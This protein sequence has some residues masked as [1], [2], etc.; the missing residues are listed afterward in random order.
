MRARDSYLKRPCPGWCVVYGLHSINSPMFN[1]AAF[2]NRL[3]K[4]ATRYPHRLSTTTALHSI[5]PHRTAH[6]PIFN[7]IR[8]GYDQTRITDFAVITLHSI[9]S[10]DLIVRPRSSRQFRLG[11]IYRI[12]L[13]GRYE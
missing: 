9:T 13:N 2:P 10:E 11:S 3:S 6:D 12:L 8:R 5:T 1:T 7:R 4:N